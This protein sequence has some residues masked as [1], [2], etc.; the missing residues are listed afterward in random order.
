MAYDGEILNHV[1]P[2]L[3]QNSEMRM[4][5]NCSLEIFQSKGNNRTLLVETSDQV[6]AQ[7]KCTY[8]EKVPVNL[9]CIKQNTVWD[10]IWN[11]NLAQ[12]QFYKLQRTQSKKTNH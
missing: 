10:Q 2:K 1:K 5:I 6:V 11:P 4:S 9:V 3:S 12:R 8:I 7:E